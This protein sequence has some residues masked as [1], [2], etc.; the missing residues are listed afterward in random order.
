MQGSK[1]TGG[2]MQSTCT[3]PAQDST[4][5]PTRFSKSTRTITTTAL[6][7]SIPMSDASRGTTSVTAPSI[8]RIGGFSIPDRAQK[9]CKYNYFEC[10]AIS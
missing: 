7:L 8:D 9:K 4:L 2:S 10:S 5:Y 1:P 6:S 3:D